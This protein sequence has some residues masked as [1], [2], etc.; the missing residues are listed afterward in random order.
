[1]PAKRPRTHTAIRMAPEAL[2]RVEQL[3]EK[4]T[5]GNVSAMLRKLVVEALQVRDDRTEASR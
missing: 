2:K 3:A 5:E 1:M 4:E